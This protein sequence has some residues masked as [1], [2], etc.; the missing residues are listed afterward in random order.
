VTHAKLSRT[1]AALEIMGEARELLE[2]ISRSEP[3]EGNAPGRGR[4]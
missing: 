1:Q 2:E 3:D 4:S